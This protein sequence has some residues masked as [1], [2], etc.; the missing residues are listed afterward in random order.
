MPYA[1]EPGSRGEQRPPC[2]EERSL[3]APPQIPANNAPPEVPPA[4]DGTVVGLEGRL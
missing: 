2:V 4:G 1:P 3:P